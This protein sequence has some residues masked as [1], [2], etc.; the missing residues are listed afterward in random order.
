M[1]LNELPPGLLAVI[2]KIEK[3]EKETRMN[4]LGFVPGVNIMCWMESPLKDP[5]MYRLLGTSVA[6]RNEDAR[7]IIVKV[8]SDV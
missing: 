8:I 4:D 7:Y 3:T 2:E 1:R 6:L 5:R